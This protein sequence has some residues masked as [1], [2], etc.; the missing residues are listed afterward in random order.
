MQVP[1]ECFVPCEKGIFP[2][3]SEAQAEGLHLPLTKRFPEDNRNL[4]FDSL[5]TEKE[6]PSLDVITQPP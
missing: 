5:D 3:H 6:C 4:P 2:P 1:L